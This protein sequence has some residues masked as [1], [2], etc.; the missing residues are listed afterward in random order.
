MKTP[1][2]INGEHMPKPEGKQVCTICPKDSAKSFENWDLLA[3]HITIV[4]NSNG[5]KRSF[6]GGSAP[7]EILNHPDWNGYEEDGS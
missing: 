4:H 1:L 2:I 6:Y 7:L 5:R 3:C